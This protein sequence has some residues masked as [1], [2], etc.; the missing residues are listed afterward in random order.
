MGAQKTKKSDP[1]Y[2][3][4]AGDREAPVH[5]VHLRAFRIGR[6]PVT[7]QEFGEFMKKD[8]YNLLNTGWRVSASSASLRIGS[9]R[10]SSEPS[11]DRGQLVRGRCDLRL[12]GR[13]IAHR[14]GMGAGSER[15][16]GLQVSVGRNQQP[17]DAS[18]ELRR[19]FWGCHA[20]WLV[21]GGKYCRGLMRYAGQRWEWCAD[22]FGPYGTEH[23][24]HF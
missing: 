18:R 15:S 20:G 2:D 3:P 14:S 21:P 17:L 12:G 8:G 13:S 19:G 22:W 7:V 23:Y 5:V 10:K 4:D 24:G 1:N 6:F 9:G 16:A 11:C